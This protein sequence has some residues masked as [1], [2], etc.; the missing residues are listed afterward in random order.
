[1]VPTSRTS[2]ARPLRSASRPATRRTTA[3]RVEGDLVL[4]NV[5]G[6]IGGLDDD[7]LH[8]NDGPGTFIGN[9]GNDLFYGGLGAD[10][11][12]GGEGVDTV[13]YGGHPGPVTVNIAV[14][15]R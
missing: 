1:M 4:G 8:G 7:V 14:A 11:F 2:P 12:I 13:A 5:E 6:A 15:G 3:R 10:T 9:G